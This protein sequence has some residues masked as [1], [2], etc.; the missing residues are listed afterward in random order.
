MHTI[1]GNK[2][3]V[4]ETTEDDKTNVDSST[5]TKR[6]KTSIESD[7]SLVRMIGRQFIKSHGHPLFVVVAH[8]ATAEGAFE[9]WSNMHVLFKP[10]GARDVYDFSYDKGHADGGGY[11]V[12]RIGNQERRYSFP[13]IDSMYSDIEDTI[14]D[15]S[16]VAKMIAF[17]ATLNFSDG[18][19]RQIEVILPIATPTSELQA[20][21]ISTWLRAHPQWTQ[22]RSNSVNNKTTTK[23]R[24]LPQYPEGYIRY[25]GTE[26]I[27]C[28]R[29]SFN[30]PLVDD[31]H[32]DIFAH[33]YVNRRVSKRAV[34]S[35]A[36]LNAAAA[37]TSN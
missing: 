6:V 35:A 26:G 11:L 29:S 37:T 36:T 19:F 23:Y 16:L 17:D 30:P 33:K 21:T 27:E 10:T 15:S 8:D 32:K 9:Q 25:K 20:T 22:Q 13:S 12:A 7:Q 4:D 18:R 24:V 2:R 5:E 34:K 31:V 1:S 3:R 14:L 28:I